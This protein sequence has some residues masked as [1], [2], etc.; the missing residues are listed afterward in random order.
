MAL[1]KS[2]QVAAGYP[3]LTPV[4]AV[5]GMTIV[6]EYVTKAGLALNDVIEMGAIPEGCIVTEFKAVI[7]DLDSNGT[8]LVSLDAGL[9][10]GEYGS[11]DSARTCGA[12]FLS[13]D[14]TG[15]AGGVVTSTV[16]AGHILTPTDAPRGFGFKIAA[17]AATLVVGAKIRTYVHVIPAPSGI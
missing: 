7:Q 10:S 8:P 15:R 5:G 2:K 9:L 6:S 1:H 4:N 11:D 3:V 17:A 14:T 16:L 13:G 12:Q